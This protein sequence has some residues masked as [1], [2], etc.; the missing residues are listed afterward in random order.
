MHHEIPHSS[1]IV[2]LLL[3]ILSCTPRNFSPYLVIY[4]FLPFSF[5]F[6][7]FSSCSAISPVFRTYSSLS[8]FPLHFP[9]FLIFSFP[10]RFSHTY[11]LPLLFSPS[12]ISF[13]LPFFL[14]IKHSSFCYFIVNLSFSQHLKI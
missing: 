11:L 8:S 7:L 12:T 13:F 14:V 2:F 6:H 1:F 5:H 4:F 10:S 9:I 3:Y